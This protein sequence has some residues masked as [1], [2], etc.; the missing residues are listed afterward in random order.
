MKKLNL[1]LIALIITTI[2]NAQ[3]LKKC[4]TDFINSNYFKNHPGEN[5]KQQKIEKN[6]QKIIQHNYTLRGVEELYTIPLVIHVLHLGED[7]GEGNNISDA[8][9]FSGIKQLNEAFSNT[10]NEGIDMNIQFQLAIQTPNG[11]STNGILRVDASNIAG[12]SENGV[13]LQLLGADQVELKNTSKWD[14]N[15]YYNIWIVSEIEGNNGGYGTQGFAYFPG[16]SATY[17]GTIIMNTSWGNMGTVNEWNNQGTTLT[18]ELG[19]SLGLYH[20]F[21]VQGNGSD[22]TAIGCPNNASCSSQGDFCC[23]TDPHK[24]SSSNSCKINDINECTGN[25]YGNVVRNFMDYSSQECQEIFSADQRDRMRATLEGSRALFLSSRAL[26]EPIVPCETVAISAN[27]TPTTQADG[28]SKHYAGIREYRFFD[29]LNISSFADIDGGYLNETNNCVATAF[30][31]PDSTYKFKI[32][33][34]GNPVNNN[35]IKAWIDFNNDDNF[36]AIEE[37]YDNQIIAETYDSIDVT[38][39][40]YAE[41]GKFLKLRVLVDLNPISDACHNPQYGQAEDYSVYIY[42]ISLITSTKNINNNKNLAISPNPASKILNIHFESD[43][44]SNYHVLDLQGRT[45][46][47]G[48][49]KNTNLTHKIDVSKYKKGVYILSVKNSQ[50]SVNRNFVVK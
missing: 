37:I 14:N 10:N 7:E 16:A 35:F 24:M 27:C 11:E 38:I 15:N 26:N 47:I 22:T 6:L 19:H 4:G 21:D 45:V 48:S 30:V 8:Q 5:I 13:A 43:E 12:Y 9:I 2:A 39:P 3:H 33:V 31:N 49:L 41:T 44:E 32:L 34:E 23:D 42:N 46:Q 25:I 18:H 40:N 20:T 36:S 1:V 50:G 28:L 29:A 17:D